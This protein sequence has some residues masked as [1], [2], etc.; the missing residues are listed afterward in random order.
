MFDISSISTDEIQY[1]ILIIVIIYLIKV[2]LTPQ[3]PIVPAVPR[4]VPV[5]EKRDYTLKELSKYTGADENLPILVGIKDKVYDVTYKHSTYGPGGAYHV[6][7]GHDAAYCLAVNSTS[8]SDLDKPLDES[9]LTQ[10]QLDT[11][12][13]WISF[14]GERYP[15]LGKL[16]V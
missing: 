7:S 16:I 6:F 12:S 1:A 5:A 14:F 11:L 15:V 10:E 2:L 9:K 13:N 8:E 4:K 3:K